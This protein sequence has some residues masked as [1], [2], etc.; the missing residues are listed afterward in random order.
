MFYCF[1]FTFS[2]EAFFIYCLVSGYNH[3]LEELYTYIGCLVFAIIGPVDLTAGN[4]NS[5]T[6]VY[7]SISPYLNTVIINAFLS[8]YD[9]QILKG[10]H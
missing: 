7:Y 8:S 6:Y 1:R 10:C 2:Y 4:I 9:Q 3:Y 5:L